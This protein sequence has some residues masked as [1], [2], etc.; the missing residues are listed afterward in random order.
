VKAS[1][2][3]YLRSEQLVP[4]FGLTDLLHTI[5]PET[6]FDKL[7]FLIEN[8]FTYAHRTTT[9]ISFT[10]LLAL[11]LLR[12]FKVTFKKH[13]WIYR[14]PEVLVVVIISTSTLLFTIGNLI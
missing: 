9:F 12:T 10:A 14:L 13:W 4:M 11:V 7:V 8:V 5:H 2:L 6:T 1:G 3:T